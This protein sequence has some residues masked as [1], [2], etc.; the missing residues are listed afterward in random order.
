MSILIIFLGVLLTIGGFC[1]LFTPIS[2]TFGIMYFF[3][4][5]LFVSGISMIIESIATKRFGLDFVFGILSLIA[6]GFIVFSPNLS[7]VTELILLYIMAG[8]LVLRGIVGLVYSVK[9]KQLIGGGG[10]FV[11][12]LLI[13]ILV[14]CAG[15]YSFVHP[16]FF[17]G[18]LGILASCF[19]IVEGIDM[20]VS[21]VIGRKIER[22]L[23]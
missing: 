7:F 23:L 1:C 4:I 19:F 11:I 6:G 14:I 16:A 12:S 18:F 20:I 21:G 15:I 13:A 5:L 3:T 9:A 10:V 22:T 2:T 8:W 17:A